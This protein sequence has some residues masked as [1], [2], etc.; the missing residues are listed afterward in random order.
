MKISAL[1]LMLFSTVVW[2]ETWT[3]TIS[4]S[5]C[6][7]KHA[8]ASPDSAA[9]V[10]KC[11][12]DGASPVFIH[13]GKVLKISNPDAVKEHLGEKVELTGDLTGD[14]ISVTKISAAESD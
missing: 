12:G 10:K 3:G 1:I 5:N 8:D 14:T 7:A 13:D 9:C 11:V 6:G 2:A 4:D